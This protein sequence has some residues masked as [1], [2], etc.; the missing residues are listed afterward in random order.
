[1][2]GRLLTLVALFLVT[3]PARAASERSSSDLFV[4]PPDNARGDGAY[5]RF[6]GDFALGVAA[7]AELDISRSDVRPALLA[8]LRFYQ[9]LGIA[10]GLS[11]S[12]HA[13]DPLERRLFVGATLEPLF[14]LRW[15]KYNHT[16]NAFWDL[17]V[18]SLGIHAGAA[19]HESRGGNFG[20]SAVANLGFGAGV[21]LTGS[22]K[23]L[24]ARARMDV[25]L[26][27]TSPAVLCLIGLEWQFFF[28]SP[29]V[30]HSTD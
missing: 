3:E 5:H 29:W 14:L 12:L 25:E 8:T 28:E 22:A 18:D 27:A 16:G 24:W 10:A 20:S 11:Q 2:T 26:G 15:P 1:M 7:H 30:R 21:P 23:G 17:T 19:F 9:T 13:T 4:P 6:D